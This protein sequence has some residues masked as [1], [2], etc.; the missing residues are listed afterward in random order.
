MFQILLL[1]WVGIMALLMCLAL[2]TEGGI[3]GIEPGWLF[4][5]WFGMSVMFNLLFFGWATNN[6]FNHFR[7][8]AVMTYDSIKRF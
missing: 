4:V 5:T 1:P 6:F 3:S 8:H 7:S 2:L